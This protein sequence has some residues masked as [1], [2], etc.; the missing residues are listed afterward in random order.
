MAKSR[1][2]RMFT[3]GGG[4]PTPGH[5]PEFPETIQMKR[6]GARVGGGKIPVQKKMTNREKGQLHKEMVQAQKEFMASKSRTKAKLDKKLANHTNTYNELKD[7]VDQNVTMGTRDNYYGYVSPPGSD[8][9]GQTHTFHEETIRTEKKH[10][11]AMGQSRV[12]HKKRVTTGR[13]TTRSLWNIVKTNGLSRYVLFDTRFTTAASKYEVTPV[14]KDHING[15]N[16][17][18]FTVLSPSTYVNMSD[19]ID[20]TEV[21]TGSLPEISSSSRKYASILDTTSEIMIHNQNRFHGAKVKI[22]LVKPLKETSF[23]N[24][25]TIQTN[26]AESVFN[27]NVTIQ[28][29]CRVPLYQQFSVPVL[30][31]SA[32]EAKQNNSTMVSVEMS[33]KGRGLLD[34]DYFRDHYEIVKTSGITLLAGETLNYRHTHCYGPGFDL[35]AV[36]DTTDGIVY[37][38][39]EPTSYFFILEQVGSD[40][41]ELSYTYDTDKYNTYLGKNPVYLATEFRK[42]IRYVN[43]ESATSELDAGGV[44]PRAVHMRFWDSKSEWTATSSEKEFNLPIANITSVSPA[45][46]GS[47]NIFTMT[48][49]TFAQ[50]IHGSRPNS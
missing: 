27:A 4:R 8:T 37:R 24:L 32:D 25:N 19:I 10:P 9:S 16:Q 47:G 13:P 43:L 18:T 44:Q 45:P 15:F 42:S 46:V 39:T 11:R 35:A 6:T 5:F 38:E 34:S 2:R 23:P 50:S 40:T 3:V 31:S 33:L 36:C 30:T 20:I 1:R 22:H 28:E 49:L 12:V 48:D 21:N 7:R 26:I 29:D 41:I 14:Q 17:R